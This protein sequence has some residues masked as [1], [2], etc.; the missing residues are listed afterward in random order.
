PSLDPDLPEHMRSARDVHVFRLGA[1]PSHRGATPDSGQ[2]IGPWPITGEGPRP[3]RHLVADLVGAP[4][5]ST[6][7]IRGVAGEPTELCGGF[8]PAIDVRFTREGLPV[9][10]LLCY[11]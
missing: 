5:V 4:R 10:V 6:W 2:R 8:S 7:G 1:P 11:K 3:K 9:D